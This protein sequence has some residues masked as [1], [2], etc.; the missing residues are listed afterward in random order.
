VEGL[1]YSDMST[2]LGVTEG[3]IRVAC[4]R[5]RRRLEAIYMSGDQG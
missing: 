4:H 5:A 1:D 2:R 3:A